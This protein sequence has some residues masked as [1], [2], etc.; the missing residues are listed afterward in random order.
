MKTLNK[1]FLIQGV[2]L[3]F[4]LSACN[5]GKYENLSGA[6]AEYPEFNLSNITYVFNDAEKPATPPMKAYTSFKAACKKG[7]FNKIPTLMIFKNRENAGK[8]AS[9]LKTQK[10]QE[11]LKNMKFGKLYYEG[12]VFSTFYFAA[13]LPDG[14]MQIFS[15]SAENGENYFVSIPIHED[16]SKNLLF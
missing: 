14:N 3:A 13:E 2:A 8:F 1:L 4:A 5:S 12:S 10:T 15:V 6:Y 7:D 16:N 11:I 9:A